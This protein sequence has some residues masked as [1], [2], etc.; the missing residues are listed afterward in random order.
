[1]RIIVV[2]TTVFP[3]MSTFIQIYLNGKFLFKKIHFPPSSSHSL[4]FSFILP[5]MNRF[6]KLASPAWQQYQFFPNS[7]THLRIP[8]IHPVIHKTI[9]II[10]VFHYPAQQRD[11]S[12]LTHA[13]TSHSLWDGPFNSCNYGPVCVINDNTAILLTQPILWAILRLIALRKMSQVCE[14]PWKMHL[15]LPAYYDAHI[16]Q[17]S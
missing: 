13:P 12:T 7:R 10:I 17:D 3:F 5:S 2:V 9:F 1:M 14:A 6:V 15:H 4:S 11:Q 16:R 8:S